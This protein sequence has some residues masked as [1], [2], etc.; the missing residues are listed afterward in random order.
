M[1][2]GYATTFTRGRFNFDIT[3]HLMLGPGTIREKYFKKLGIADQIEWVP[4]ANTAVKLGDKYLEAPKNDIIQYIK[5][6]KELFPSEVPSID[7]YMKE[8]LAYNAELIK[9]LENPAGLNQLL[10]PIKNYSL[11]KLRNS[12]FS[13]F[14]R[15]FLT[16]ESLLDMINAN[17]IYAGVPPS[18]MNAFM[19]ILFMSVINGPVVYDKHKGNHLI[20]ILEKEFLKNG[21]E[22]LCTNNIE[23]VLISQDKKVEGVQTKRGEVYPANIVVNAGSALN[24]F[25]KMIP[26]DKSLLPQKYINILNTFRPSLSSFMIFLGLNKDITPDV[27]CHNVVLKSK[28][29]TNQDYTN[30]KEGKIEDLSIFVTIYNNYYPEYSPQGTTT[31]T[32]LVLCGFDSWKKYED[33]YLK[34]RKEEYK[35]EKER[36]MEIL[37]DKVEEQLIPGLKDMIEVKEGSSPLTNLRYTS[38]NDGAC[39]GYESDNNY[40]THPLPAKSP[41]DGLYLAGHWSSAHGYNGAIES[42]FNSFEAINKHHSI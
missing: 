17:W 6:L 13:D 22:V 16:N 35:K 5:S 39:Y 21:G 3:L 15:Q 32:V 28:F 10:F 30:A 33:D 20:Q 1:N 34:G 25:R 11:F 42:G 26:Q 31:I 38:N 8:I 40:T 37:L 19:G 9:F 41:I 29:K 2:I 18:R 24:L 12:V 36:W 23:K 7:K 27:K 14:Q 4:T